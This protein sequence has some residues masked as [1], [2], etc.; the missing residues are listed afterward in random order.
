MAKDTKV[1]T[2]EEEQK[3]IIEAQ[4]RVAEREK[5]KAPIVS[6]TIQDSTK[7]VYQ[8]TPAME[9]ASMEKPKAEFPSYLGGMSMM[10]GAMKGAIGYNPYED[11]TKIAMDKYNVEQNR[12]N[13]TVQRLATPEVITEYT[14][15]DVNQANENQTNQ[16]TER[17]LGQADK[18]LAL[19]SKK[20]DLIKEE[21]NLKLGKSDSE[22]WISNQFNKDNINVPSPF[23]V[24]QDWTPDSVR[25][26]LSGALESIKAY[27]PNA[28]LPDIS[29]IN[30]DG[31]KENND[32]I[33][34]AIK[35]IKGY[36]GNDFDINWKDTGIFTLA[37]VPKEN[38]SKLGK[39]VFMGMLKGSSVTGGGKPKQ[40]TANPKAQE[41][42]N[43]SNDTSI[44]IENSSVS[45]K[46]AQML[47]KDKKIRESRAKEPQPLTLLP[48]YIN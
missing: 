28:S 15:R 8:K 44:N 7:V 14:A 12:L 32:A 11:F 46:V 3:A 13:N 39:S 34:N 26:S 21:Q 24:G 2:P 4:K 38:L 19:E 37:K 6:N 40:Q 43:N 1:L 25:N 22:A 23:L 35:T 18:G 17:Q 29:R 41:I 36:V 30:L 27:Y 45:S 10:G 33:S 42:K 20:L 48:T 16:Y 47:A 9:S 31:S 5:A